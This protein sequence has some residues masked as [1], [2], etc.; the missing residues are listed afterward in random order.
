M[1]FEPSDDQAFSRE[2]TRT[3]LE[4]ESPITAV[5]GFSFNA[6]GAVLRAT[7]ESKPA[8]PSLGES[9]RSAARC[10]RRRRRRRRGS[11]DSVHGRT[12]AT[13]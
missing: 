12:G 2:T 13:R 4:S 7:I 3:F 9:S 5:R 10:S 1:D 6:Q 8:E 11:D